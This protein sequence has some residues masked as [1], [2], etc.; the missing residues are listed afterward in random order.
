MRSG[1]EP[2]AFNYARSGHEGA[3]LSSKSLARPNHFR[4]V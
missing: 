4:K 3:K 1:D 2:Q